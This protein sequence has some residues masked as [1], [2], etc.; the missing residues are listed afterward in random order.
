[1]PKRLRSV[2]VGYKC[3]SSRHLA[4][5]RQWLGMG[6]RRGGGGAPPL[7]MRPLGRGVG[8]FLGPMGWGLGTTGQRPASHPRRR[9]S[10]LHSKTLVAT[11]RLG[12]GV[13]A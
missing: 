11:R 1:M 13:D 3:H 8:P 6:A 10:R 7:P 9:S 5:G 4:S 12:A 2:T